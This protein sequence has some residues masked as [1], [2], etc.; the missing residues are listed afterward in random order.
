ML[1]AN[2]KVHRYILFITLEATSAPSSCPQPSAR[3]IRILS[4]QN[5]MDVYESSH[6]RSIDVVCE[7][8]DV[9]GRACVRFTR[10]KLCRGGG[11]LCLC[12]K[13]QVGT[14]RISTRKRPVFDPLLSQ[15]VTL[16]TTLHSLGR[17]S[18]LKDFKHQRRRATPTY[19]PVKSGTMNI[20]ML[21]N[22]S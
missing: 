5:T 19:M 8:R 12:G 15:S 21:N 10:R 9:A 16:L 3:G 14:P 2:L 13:R 6:Y 17:R 18:A 22:V 7:T 4:T 20:C 1:L 11:W